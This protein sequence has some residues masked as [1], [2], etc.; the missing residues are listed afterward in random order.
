[1]I[2]V[3]FQGEGGSTG[4]L[5]LQQAETV[6]LIS[7]TQPE[8]TAE[9]IRDE[10]ESEADTSGSRGGWVPLSVTDIEGGE[11]LLLRQISRGTHVGRAIDAVVT[12][13]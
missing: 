13:T 10:S 6:R 2:M 12:E 11:D 9:K 3:E 8:V 1:M 5:F 7:P 4:Q